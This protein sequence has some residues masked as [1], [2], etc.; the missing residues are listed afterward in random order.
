M[1][2]LILAVSFL[3]TTSAIPQNLTKR[4][5]G[6]VSMSTSLATTSYL[7]AG[8]HLVASTGTFRHTGAAILRRGISFIV[9]VELEQE[10]RA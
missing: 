5:S 7:T 1:L 9:V 6:K 2:T 4:S 3:L 10:L 8:R